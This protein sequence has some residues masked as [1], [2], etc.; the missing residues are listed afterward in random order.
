VTDTTEKETNERKNELTD[1]RRD[2]PLH[3]PARLSL[4]WSLTLRSFKFDRFFYTFDIRSN[5]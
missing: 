3:P 2:A 1:G 5:Y 4:R